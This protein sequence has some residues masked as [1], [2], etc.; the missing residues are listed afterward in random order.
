MLDPHFA[1]FAGGGAATGVV[2]TAAAGVVAAPADAAVMVLF[3]TLPAFL[4]DAAT[5]GVEPPPPAAIFVIEDFFLGLFALTLPPAPAPGV[6]P[7]PPLPPRGAGRKRGSSIS[8]TGVTTDLRFFLEGLLL[9]AFSCSC[10][11]FTCRGGTT[12]R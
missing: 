7:V 5:P 8:M 1:F 12:G 10:T 4:P 9:R 3:L 2:A 11:I 6:P